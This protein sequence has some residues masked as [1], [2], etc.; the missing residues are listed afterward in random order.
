LNWTQNIPAYIQFVGGLMSYL[1]YLCLF[2][3]I[4]CRPDR[5]SNS[6]HQWW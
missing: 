2:A 1:R 6:Q 4:G 3:Y 5:D